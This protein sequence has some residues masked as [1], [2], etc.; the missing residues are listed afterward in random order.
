M[1][2]LAA[3]IDDVPLA[4]CDLETTGLAPSL[5]DRVC[6]V[7]ILRCESG[8]VVD[9]L[10]Q[11]VNPRRSMSRGAYAVHGIDEEMLR[12]APLFSQVANDLLELLD[13]AV[14]VGHNATFDLGFLA[15][16]LGR[17][18]VVLPSLVALDTLR[19][20]R[21]NYHFG[22]YSLQ[23]L[24]RALS[25]DISGRGHRAMTDVL[26]TRALFWRL[27]DDLWQRSVRSVT[28]YV[29]AQGGALRISPRPVL[30]VPPPIRQALLENRLLF[31]R[32]LSLQGEETER[33]VRPVRVSERGG[34]LFLLAHCLLRDAQR[35]FRLDRILEVGTV[36]SFE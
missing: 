25:I 9:A 15:A 36:E 1:L 23:R 7:A 32:Y 31:L 18:G 6:E 26:T 30:D 34:N 22:S 33:L 12:D 4:F 16:E 24:A 11:L 13:D 8:E 14:F 35:S 21:R 29:A 2:D 19:L 17:L 28:D 10:Q 27:A 5:G 3:S 20:A